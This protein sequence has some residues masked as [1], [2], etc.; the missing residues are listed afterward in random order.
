[1]LSHRT[2]PRHGAAIMGDNAYNTLIDGPYEVKQINLSV[3]T[4]IDNIGLMNFEKIR[5]ILKMFSGYIGSLA[6]FKPQIIYITPTVADTGFY[7]DFI[8]SLIAKT[9]RFFFNSKCRI[10]Y[11]IHMRPY[12]TGSFR[13]KVLF[14]VF[15]HKAETIFNSVKLQEDYPGNMIDRKSN[16]FLINFVKPICDKDTAYASIQKYDR[17]GE[18][19]KPFIRIFYFGHLIETKGYRRALE[20]AKILSVHPG[21]QFHFSGSYGSTHEKDYFEKFVTD[22]RLESKVFYHGRCAENDMCNT[23]LESD[24]MI[25]PS[26][27]EAYPLTILEALSVGIPVVATDTGAIMEIVGTQN[28]IVIPFEGQEEEFVHVFATA[29]LSV[30]DTWTPTLAKACIDRFYATWTEEQFRLGMYDIMDQDRR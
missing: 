24:V 19:N 26:Y 21:I 18:N 30:I 25:F 13:R 7:R 8:L 29:I 2:P 20:I 17:S 4:A 15:F 12:G 9:Y 22:N 3:S 5:M 10:I 27:T 11:H 6:K 14:P 23:F 1:M 16:H 28:G